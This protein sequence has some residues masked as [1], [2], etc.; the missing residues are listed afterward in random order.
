MYK[1]MFGKYRIMFPLL[2]LSLSC[3]HLRAS[4]FLYFFFKL[5]LYVRN[6]K[7]LTASII[8]TYPK[9][10]TNNIL[11]VISPHVLHTNLYR[12]FFNLYVLLFSLR[13]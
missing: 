13:Q 12:T 10:S 4:I 7:T 11:L 9:E 5:F 1:N 3:T 6:V 2:N 8:F